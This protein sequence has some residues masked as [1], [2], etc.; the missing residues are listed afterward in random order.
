MY[1]GNWYPTIADTYEPIIKIESFPH[2]LTSCHW[3][4]GG[5]KKADI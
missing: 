5:D 3:E 2:Q 4:E 1:L